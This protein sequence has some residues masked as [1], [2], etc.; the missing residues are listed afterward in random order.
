MPEPGKSKK[1][2]GLF[3][4]QCQGHRLT[5]LYT[6][7]PCPGVKIR[8]RRCAVCCCRMTTREVVVKWSHS[9]GQK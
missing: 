7:H 3:C 9:V 8:Y 5:V 1:V 4:P 6:K 2:R